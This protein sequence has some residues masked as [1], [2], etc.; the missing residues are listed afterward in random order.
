MGRDVL[1]RDVVG[2]DD[3]RRHVT[4]LGRA[5]AALAVFAASVPLAGATLAGEPDPA[6]VAAARAAVMQLGSSLK[7][8]LKA[9]IKAGG[10]KSAIGVCKSIAPALAEQ[11]GAARGLKIR[12]TALRVRNPANGPDAWERNVLQQF[13]A[14]IA[15]GADPRKL[16]HAETVTDATGASVFRYMKAIPMAVQPCLT[17]HGNPEPTLKAAIT[18]LYPQDQ[19]TGFKPGELRGAFSVTARVRPPPPPGP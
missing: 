15:A 12:R 9:A 13:A 10:P 1:G 5:A 3:V 19:A 7:S 17:C 18:R 2:R 6:R 8:K 16:E 11:T 4:G 14:K